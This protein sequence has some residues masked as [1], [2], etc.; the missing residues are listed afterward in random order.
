MLG[1]RVLL[2]AVAVAGCA[3]PPP[4]VSE[5]LDDLDYHAESATEAGLS[6]YAGGA[7]ISYFLVWAVERDLADP[8]ALDDAVTGP[9][10]AR[11]P[12]AF[13]SV[14]DWYD[15]AVVTDALQSEGA[16]FAGSCYERYVNEYGAAFGDRT[17]HEPDWHDYAVAARILDRLRAEGCL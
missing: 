3:S 7:H 16:S 8:D 2:L 1:F 6:D 13:E 15:G 5:K 17:Y 9:V 11:D 4:P 10:R 14:L 12:S